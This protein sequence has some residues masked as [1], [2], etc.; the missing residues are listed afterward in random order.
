MIIVSNTAGSSAAPEHEAEANL[1]EAELGL[2][3]LRQQPGRKKPFCGPDLLEYF[4]KHGVTDD[5]AEIVVVGDRLATDVL[6]ARE[7][8]SWSVWCSEGWRNIEAPK[9]DYRGFFSK[10]E[11]RYERLMRET[12]KRTAPLPHRFIQRGT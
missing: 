9:T 3:V 6:L 8:G 7:M 5:P 12:F 1:L 10:V 4:K 11:G 2:P